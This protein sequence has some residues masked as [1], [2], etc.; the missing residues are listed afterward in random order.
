MAAGGLKRYR[1]RTFLTVPTSAADARPGLPVCLRQAVSNRR[2]RR[3]AR[4]DA[5]V[6]PDRYI[7]AYGDQL[8]RHMN[9]AFAHTSVARATTIRTSPDARFRPR[10]VCA[11]SASGRSLA[12][13]QPT[14]APIRNAIIQPGEIR[15]SQIALI[16]GDVSAV[17]PP[18]TTPASGQPTKL[19]PSGN[20]LR[21][22]DDAAKLICPPR[23]AT[24]PPSGSIRCRAGTTTRCVAGCGTGMGPDTITGSPV[25]ARQRTLACAMARG[26]GMALI[27]RR[28]IAGVP[29][30]A[31]AP[32]LSESGLWFKCRLVMRPPAG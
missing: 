12:S 22:S 5:A 4:G 27:V 18:I 30:S 20:G 19:R 17:I 11:R 14:G 13:Q 15:P 21:E 10:S 8:R 24:V 31:A 26:G 29:G 25:G 16:A 3:S 28:G 2:P 7:N 23:C 32:G 1:D 6:T 9:S